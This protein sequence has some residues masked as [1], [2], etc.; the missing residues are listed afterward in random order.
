[1]KRPAEIICNGPSMKSTL[2]PGDKIE[3]GEAA[4]DELKRGDI[5]IYSS[6]DNIRLNV[7]HRIIGRDSNGFI[8]R[9]DNNSKTD[10][11]RVRLEH[12]PLK[13]V[14][15]ERGARRMKIGKHG[16]LVH[17]LRLLQKKFELFRRKHLYSIYEFIADS[18]I[19]YPIG[20]MFNTEVRKFKRPKGIEHQL[21][22]GKHR[23]GILHPGKE[24][25]SIRFP[26]RIFIK[27]PELD[28]E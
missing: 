25:W 3:T 18:K 21:F 10:P 19:F 13:V 28:K 12:R 23:I 24:K 27:P 8:T 22:I 16:M 15:I 17:R 7:I 4:F 26:W 6:P 5:I 9:G 20:N 11:Y 1:M 14:A 2:M